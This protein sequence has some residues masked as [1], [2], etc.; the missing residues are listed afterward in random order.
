VSSGKETRRVRQVNITTRGDT[1]PGGSYETGSV[2]VYRVDRDVGQTQRCW[3]TLHTRGDSAC[4][5]HIF[6]HHSRIVCCAQDESVLAT[7]TVQGY[8]TEDLYHWVEDG[9]LVPFLQIV[10]TKVSIS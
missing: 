3:T 1:G 7:W 8:R 10:I 9:K 2:W 4:S 5:H 6:R